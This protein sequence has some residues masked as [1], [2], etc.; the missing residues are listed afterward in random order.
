MFW[1]VA[2]AV[3]GDGPAG[4]DGVA[5]LAHLIQIAA[6]AGG[7]QTGRAEGLVG[8]THGLAKGRR[9]G[10]VIQILED[11]QGRARKLANRATCTSIA[12]YTSIPGGG[13]ADERK[14]A[15]AA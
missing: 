1:G 11:D 3:G 7:D 13:G 6:R 2:V 4:K 12:S 15:V 10:R 9:Y 8:G 14:V 5:D